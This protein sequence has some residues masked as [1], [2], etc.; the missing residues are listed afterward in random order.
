MGKPVCYVTRLANNPA[1][2][3]GNDCCPHNVTGPAVDGSPNVY[4]H[5]KGAQ[6]R[7][8]RRAFDLLR[9]KY[10]GSCRGERHGVR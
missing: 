5:G 10:M 4:V 3:H 8:S 6:G 2:G 9:L 7:R 1:D